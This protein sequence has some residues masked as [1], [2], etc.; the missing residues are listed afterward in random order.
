MLR[1]RGASQSVVLG[2]LV[3]YRDDSFVC[4]VLVRT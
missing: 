4:F 3:G 2:V 1:F